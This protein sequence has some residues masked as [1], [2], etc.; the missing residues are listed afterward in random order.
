MAWSQKSCSVT[1][2]VNDWP[3]SPRDLIRLEGRRC[4]HFSVWEIGKILEENV[5]SIQVAT[6]GDWDIHC[7]LSG[8][9]LHSASL[10]A[11]IVFYIVPL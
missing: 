11:C 5:L 6:M 8:R 9:C 1:S 7:S 2:V 3:F 4:G 10:I